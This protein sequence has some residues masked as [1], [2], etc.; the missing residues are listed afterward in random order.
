M[1][2]RV[3][4]F[5]VPE[6]VKKGRADKIFAA[7]FEDVSRVRLQKAFDAGKVTFEGQVIDKRF[8]I[9]S[10]GLLRAVLDELSCGSV[11][12]EI[13]LKIL[14]EDEA[15][16]VVNKPVG[17]VTHPGSGT[18]DDTL[19]HALLHHTCGQLSLVGAP[20]RPESCTVSIRKPRGSSWSQKRIWRIISWPRPSWPKPLSAIVH[21]YWTADTIIRS[22]EGAHWAPSGGAYAYGCGPGRA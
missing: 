20:D 6:G 1:A 17:M 2:E 18:G 15:I 13:P 11:A 16:V 14:Y 8:K 3:I 4:E 12:V 9:N 10:P 5:A 22:R 21:L 19:V 7:E